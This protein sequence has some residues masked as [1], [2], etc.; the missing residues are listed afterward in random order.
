[1]LSKPLDEAFSLWKQLLEGSGIPEVRSQEQTL[2]S[3]QL[4]AELYRLQG[5]PLQALETL[6]L[7]LQLCRRL[8]ERRGTA[9]A[10]RQLSGALLQLQSPAQARVRLGNMEI[11][12][13]PGK[14]GNS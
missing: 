14:S 4:L 10:L 11:L 7:L 2:S 5:K 6:L 3:L 1:A 13:I 9:G 12:G 8:G